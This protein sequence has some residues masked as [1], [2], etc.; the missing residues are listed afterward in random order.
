VPD[1]TAPLRLLFLTLQA[2]AQHAPTD[3]APLLTPLLLAAQRCAGHQLTMRLAFLLVSAVQRC[4]RSRIVN[5]KGWARGDRE[6]PLNDEHIPNPNVVRVA[7]GYGL[8]PRREESAGVAKRPRERSPTRN[9]PKLRFAHFSICCAPAC[10]ARRLV[11]HHAR[12]LRRTVGAQVC[13][14]LLLTQLL[15]K[16]APKLP[17]D[18]W[19]AETTKLRK[20]CKNSLSLKAVPLGSSLVELYL[21]HVRAS[22][23]CCAVSRPTRGR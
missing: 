1:A 14:S 9:P 17:L 8:Q 15:E 3:L 12:S 7:L 18:A 21:T 11:P 23:P 5:A 6:W 16:Q 10:E 4:K 20:I 2:P 19:R 22:S 13:A